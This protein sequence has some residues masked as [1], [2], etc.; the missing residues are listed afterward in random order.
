MVLLFSQTLELCTLTAYEHAFE[1]THGLLCFSTLFLFF[2]PLSPSVCAP[3]RGKRA[4]QKTPSG[5]GFETKST[6]MTTKTCTSS[7]MRLFYTVLNEAKKTFI[8]LLL[9]L[10][11]G[12][13]CPRRGEKTRGFWG[14]VPGYLYVLFV[15]CFFP[16]TLGPCSV[17]SL[18][19]FVP[20]RKSAEKQY[21]VRNPR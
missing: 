10:R 21:F 16:K 3:G 4:G 1:H 15:I 13:F 12:L 6:P 9:R 7:V 11:V 20:E 14:F 19:L 5:Y 2:R 8:I 17:V 18:S